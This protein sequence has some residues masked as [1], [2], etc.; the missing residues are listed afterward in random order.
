MKFKRILALALISATTV[1][2]MAGCGSDSSENEKEKDGKVELTLSTWANETEAKEMDAVLKE[3]NDSQEEYVIKQ[4]VIPSDY[5]TKIQTQ[6]AG[7]QAPDLMWLSQEYIPAYAK[8]GAIIELDSAIEK[9]DIINLDDY[10]EGPLQT[11]KYDGKLY[12]LPWIGQPYIIYYNK[13]MFEE[14][15]VELPSE[16]WTWDEFYETAKALT[17]DD[18]YGFASTGTPPLELFTWAF[19]GDI[20][21]ADGNVVVGDPESIEGLEFAYNMLNDKTAVMPYLEANSLGVEQ[22]FAQGRIAMMVGGAADMVEKKVEEA[23]TG[24]E[25]GVQVMPAGPKAQVTFNWTASTAIS[26]QTKNP[27]VAKKALMDLTNAMFDYKIPAPVKS[28]VDMVA[29]IN[30]AKEYA[31]DVIKKSGEMSRG[32]NNQPEQNEIASYIW[33]KLV[34][35]IYTNG[36]GSGNVNVAELAEKAQSEIEK[37]TK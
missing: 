26:S 6:I 17:G 36:D 1:S 12:G 31:M 23:G 32:F 8:T 15:G 9:Q 35:P 4:Q 11:A 29:T 18:I 22:G 34:S 10:M 16:D 3:L 7:K 13:T 14:K 24:F 33:E 19:G 30:P 28:K 25:I 37:I 21:D 27:E 2:M 20:T 5:Y